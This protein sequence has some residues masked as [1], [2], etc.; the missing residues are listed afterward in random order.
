MNMAN[1]PS[2]YF[3][4]AV[5]GLFPIFLA[6]ALSKSNP[7]GTFGFSGDLSTDRRG[8]HFDVPPD[9]LASGAGQCGAPTG[10][11][12]HGS[13]AGCKSHGHRQPRAAP[14]PLERSRFRSSAH[15]RVRHAESRYSSYSNLSCISVAW[16]D[17]LSPQRRGS[18]DINPIGSSRRHMTGLTNHPV[19]SRRC[20]LRAG[21][22]ETPP[23]PPPAPP[24]IAG[25]A[26]PALL[27]PSQTAPPLIA[28]MATLGVLHHDEPALQSLGMADSAC[29]HLSCRCLK[30]LLYEHRAVGE[31]SVRA[32]G[33]DGPGRCID[34]VEL[35]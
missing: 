14:S 19:I 33:G 28:G 2:V 8:V 31:T 17:L 34:D 6:M 4:S 24:L 10:C 11:G 12:T 3:S 13:L 15:S 22:I 1:Y 26:T 27:H 23:P 25:L 35:L 18:L 5:G 20:L 21:S 30:H 29:R 9:R 16:G 7:S 32:I